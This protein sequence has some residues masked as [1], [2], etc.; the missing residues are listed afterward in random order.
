M[1]SIEGAGKQEDADRSRVNA[2]FSSTEISFANVDITDDFMFSYIM[3]NP[4]ICAELLEYMF[5]GHK[6]QKVRYMYDTDGEKSQEEGGG[7]VKEVSASVEIQ[8]TLAEAFGMRGVRLDVYLDDGKV[9][10]NVEMQNLV[11]AFLPKRTR[12][13]HSEIDGGLLRRGAKYRELKPCYV[14][15]ICKFDPFGKGLYKYTFSSRCHEVENLELGD[16]A[17]TLF[18][19]TVGTKEYVKADGTVDKVSDKLKE[20]L[21][22]MN[23]TKSYPVESSDNGLIRRI[24][25]AVGEAK[26]DSEWRRAYMTYQARIWDAEEVGEERGLKKGMERGLKK[27]EERGLKKG[28][29]TQ[30]RETAIKLYQRGNTPADIADIVGYAVEVVEKWL[31]LVTA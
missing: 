13:Y 27:G 4:D 1:D 29:E 2:D 7:L 30:A 16:D 19:S 22:Y 17:Y 5:P 25:I 14:I 8:K 24:D 20:L 18:F 23:D 3:R 31:G 12:Y 9:V 26:M 6:I 21:R 11:Q 15:F 28:K 10:Y